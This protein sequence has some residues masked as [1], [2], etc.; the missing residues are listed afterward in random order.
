VILADEPTG[1]LDKHTG[2]EIID[3]LKSLQIEK[4]VT[5]VTA[6]HDVKM[7]QISDR[8]VWVRDGLVERIEEHSQVKFTV[9]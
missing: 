1:N 4:H 6:T 3:L 9:S 5:V 2:A 7:L 8:I